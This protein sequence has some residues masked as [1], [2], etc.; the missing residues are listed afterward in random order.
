MANMSCGCGLQAGSPVLIED[1][2]RHWGHTME[3]LLYWELI[4]GSGSD[5]ALREKVA[6]ARLAI[7][8]FVEQRKE[9]VHPI[10]AAMGLL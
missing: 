10:A 9:A 3:C 4:V 6:A 7:G 1:M 8:E 2:E 5:P